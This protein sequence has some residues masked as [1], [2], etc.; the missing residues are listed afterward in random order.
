MPANNI[1]NMKPDAEG[2]YLLKKF[3]GKG[4]WTY[5]LIPE[6]EPNTHTHFGWVRVKG[7]I[8][9]IPLG[10]TR[11]MPSGNGTLFLAVNAALRKKTGKAAGDTVHIVLYRDD[12]QP[13]VPAELTECLNDAPDAHRRFHAL[14]ESRQWDIIQYIYDAKTE[15]IKANRIA[16]LIT[17]LL[18]QAD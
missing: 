2:N 15:E 17:K 4:G 10:N 6:I 16:G 12:L 14:P 7:F 18:E 8:D 5:A 11:L 1:K 13:G 3:A 9:N